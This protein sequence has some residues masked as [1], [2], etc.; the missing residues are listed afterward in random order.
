MFYKHRKELKEL[1][2][3]PRI[4][5][6]EK[7]KRKEEKQ[8]NDKV[9]NFHAYQKLKFQTLKQ[10]AKKFRRCVCGI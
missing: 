8:V 2:R 4:P 7:P 9:S 6:M 1:Q 3:K 10:K 5:L